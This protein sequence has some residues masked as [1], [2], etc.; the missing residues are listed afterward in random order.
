MRDELSLPHKKSDSTLVGVLEKVEIN[1]RVQL[2]ISIASK[3]L[4][5]FGDTLISN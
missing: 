4:N 5:L 3:T 2:D 1:D